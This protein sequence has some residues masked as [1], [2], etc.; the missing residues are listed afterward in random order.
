[1]EALGASRR[2]ESSVM[3]TSVRPCLALAVAV[4]LLLTAAAGRAASPARAPRPA[5]PAAG[6]PAAASSWL[7]RLLAAV[8]APVTP[9]SRA[10]LSGHRGCIDPNGTPCS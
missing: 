5:A 6:L 2:G 10:T 8:R 7:A 4:A 9:S 3:R 1:M